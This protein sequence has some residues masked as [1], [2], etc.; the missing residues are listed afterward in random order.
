MVPARAKKSAHHWL[1][2]HGRYCC[3]ARKPRCGA[4]LIADLCGYGAKVSKACLAFFKVACAGVAVN[5]FCLLA[6]A[7][8]PSDDFKLRAYRVK[9]EINDAML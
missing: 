5:I 3:V 8:V 6:T 4:C 1:I 7:P 9:C 2:L